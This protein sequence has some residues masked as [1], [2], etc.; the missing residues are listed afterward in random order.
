MNVVRIFDGNWITNEI[1]NEAAVRRLV[2]RV[3]GL[4]D[5]AYILDKRATAQ[6]KQVLASMRYELETM[7]QTAAY[8]RALKALDRYHFVMLVGEPASGKSTIAATLAMGAIDRDREMQA[9]KV[10]SP[11]DFLRHYDPDDPRQFFWV[12]DAFGP[13]QFQ[14]DLA[15]G[16]TRC[17]RELNAAI[18]QGAYVVFTSRDYIYG[19]AKA[20][21]MLTAFPLMRT[22]EVVIDVNEIEPSE[23][24]AILYNHIKLGNQ[25]RAFKTSVK[26]FLRSIS[27]HPRFI[28]E[29][30]RRLGDSFY[31][32]QVD[33]TYD[34]LHDFVSRRGDYLVESIEKADSDTRA[35]LLVLFMSG[36]YIDSPISETPDLAA[37]L[38]YAGCSLP[39]L[40]ST[41]KALDGSLVMQETSGGRVRWTFRH[42]TLRDAIAIV[43]ASD[44][45][46]FEAYVR[47][48][49]IDDQI[50]EVRCRN[51]RLTG[52]RVILPRQRYA[53]FWDRLCH[54][55][56][57]KIINFLADRA[58]D[59]FTRLALGKRPA[60]LG[61][62][63]AWP[64][65]ASARA[66]LTRA[67]R[68]GILPED[69]RSD[70]IAGLRELT[71]DEPSSMALTDNA[72]RS[73][74]SPVEI[75]EFA[76]ILKEAIVDRIDQLVETWINAYEDDTDGESY[77]EPLTEALNALQEHYSGD[78]MARYDIDQARDVID[79]GMAV[80]DEMRKIPEDTDGVSDHSSHSWRDP[81]D[82]IDE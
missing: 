40:R 68:L 51:V 76:G 8:R 47:G 23:R 46:L 17:F 32:E 77:F 19:S 66:V 31:T 4:G 80:V 45:E 56:T 18:R 21:L 79:N 74:L 34:G 9:F 14:R 22:A 39:E 41:M 25:S 6:T 60:L 53:D 81:F 13:T 24:I 30:A 15:E 64:Q 28:P 48:T 65:S 62:A 16:W 36:G 58:D 35:A 70:F 27:S 37:I 44:V 73:L 10:R 38:R 69:A 52:A 63:A 33:I 50:N 54:L 20:Q 82:D 71:T 5:L 42:P 11:D 1:Y 12:D 59:E 61:T 57:W 78:F 75:N 2:P 49:T 26:H 67:S 29:V 3:Y 55:D 43:V 72:I 7:V